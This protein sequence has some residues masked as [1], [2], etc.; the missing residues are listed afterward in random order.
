MSFQ[1]QL[2][3]ILCSKIFIL[4]LC[5]S[6]LENLLGIQPAKWTI[7]ETASSHNSRR[8]LTL[9]TWL[10]GNFTLEGNWIWVLRYEQN[11]FQAVYQRGGIPGY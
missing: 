9:Y 5:S 2:L 10:L 7:G 4:L 11:F 1:T 3:L 6:A 8:G